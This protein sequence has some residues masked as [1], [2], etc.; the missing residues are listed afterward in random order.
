[1]AFKKVTG[2]LGQ[3]IRWTEQPKDQK[4]AE[5]T[6]YIGD[7]IEGEYLE[8]RE[9]VGQN[10]ACMYVVKTEQHGTVCVW[11][12]TVLGDKMKEVPVGSLVQI[13]YLGEQ[14]PKKGGKSYSGFEVQYDD[15]YKPN[16]KVAKGSTTAEE[17]DAM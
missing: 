6:I 3:I 1:M 9:G 4:Q 17:V 13:Q 5:K 11:D 7:I 8:L 16:L 12:T 15:E 14:E 2:N 10:G